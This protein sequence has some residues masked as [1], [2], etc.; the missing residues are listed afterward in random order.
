MIV[1]AVFNNYLDNTTTY[2]AIRTAFINA[3]E[4][5]FC[6][7]SSEVQSVTDAWYAVGVGNAFQNASSITGP[8]NVC[9]SG[10]S[11][12]VNNLPV[13]AT[14]S[15]STTSN[16]TRNSSQGSNPCTFS[17][18]G[19][20]TGWIRAT[21]VLPG[22]CGN[23]TM[24]QNDVQVGNP[25]LTNN[26]VFVRDSYYNNLSGSGTYSNPYVVCDGEEYVINMDSNNVNSINYT[27]IPSGWTSYSYGIYEIAFTPNNMN[28]GN[29]YAI[30]VDYAGACGNSLHTIYFKKDSYCFGWFFKVAPNPITSTEL[31]IIKRDN[32]E[33]TA[34]SAN[35]EVEFLLFN[36]KGVSL[37]SKKDLA[38][39]E[40]Y[41][42]NVNNLKNG[43][44]YLKV[45]TEKP[46]MKASLNKV[47]TE[48]IF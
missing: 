41:K 35:T 45:I 19:N 16:I 30:D 26:D 12:T 7:N 21:I 3:A 28:Y 43:I 17:A 42:L 9:S 5:I 48:E 15:W 38:N 29:T 31:N 33:T 39:K 44:Y 40:N 10:V 2:P 20:G 1:E 6:E 36:S 14:I 25:T 47:I 22:N 13:G 24:I 18:N 34:F 11:F 8:I 32:N 23:P 46:I 27:T 37:K 4:A